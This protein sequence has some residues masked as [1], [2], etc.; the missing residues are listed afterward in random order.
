MIYFDTNVLVYATILDLDKSKHKISTRLIINAIKERLLFISPLVVSE[1]VYVL[2]KSTISNDLIKQE[3]DFYKKYTDG[4]I[5]KD[6]ITKAFDLSHNLNRNS[7]I[8][9]SIHI[10]LAEKYCDKLVTFDKGYKTFI[11]KVSVIIDLIE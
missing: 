9:D 8:N 7:S 6:I 1:Y 2:S 10:F 11:N 5:G 3:V 4:K